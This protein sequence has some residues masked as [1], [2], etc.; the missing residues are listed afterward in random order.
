MLTFQEI[1]PSEPKAEFPTLSELAYLF[2]KRNRLLIKRLV[3]YSF[4]ESESISGAMLD[5]SDAGLLN[6]IGGHQLMRV[7]FLMMR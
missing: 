1:K 3:P 6:L 7:E 2:A 4:R 5:F